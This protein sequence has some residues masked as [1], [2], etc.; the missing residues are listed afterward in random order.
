MDY[1]LGVQLAE[2]QHWRKLL[3]G[4]IVSRQR[5]AVSYRSRPSW[6][7]AYSPQ[8]VIYTPAS[9]IAPPPSF[10][11]ARSASPH[12]WSPKSAYLPPIAVPNSPGPVQRKRSALDAFDHDIP[13]G[14]SIYEQVRL[15]ARKAAFGQSMTPA[16]TVQPSMPVS[17]RPRPQT[18][19]QDSGLSRSSSLN[20]QIARIPSGRRGSAGQAY[21]DA[22]EADLRHA[23][24]NH[25]Q[26]QEWDHRDVFG[27]SSDWNGYSALMAPYE[28]PMEVQAVPPQVNCSPYLH[29]HSLTWHQ[30]LMF[31]SLAAESH[32]GQDG[33]PRKAILCYQ[34]P[35][36]HSYPPQPQH[37][38]QSQPHD[39]AITYNDP[40]DLSNVHPYSFPPM[41]T[42]SRFHYEP[43][44][45]QFANAG[46]PG[47]AYN[48][49]S[50]SWEQ[51]GNRWST[52]SEEHRYPS[53][54]AAP[55]VWKTRSEWSSPM[56][57]YE[58]WHP[59]V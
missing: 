14:T 48:P 42:A 13:L 49:V 32:P 55:L 41:T 51:A 17:G 58:G 30:H 39:L 8:S 54:S 37:T 19:H 2:Y 47:Y 10:D 23:A 29:K 36:A 52:G 31:Y 9:T 24:T 4:F 12:A 35:N 27:G 25:A 22:P 53:G 20:R 5:E 26:M 40:S 34:D 46:P 45:A 56:P 7:P 38:Y 59:Q 50:S 3:D 16:Y 11:G 57:G 1:D 15:P 28:R 43:E 18:I 44:P 21:Y 6:T 33:A